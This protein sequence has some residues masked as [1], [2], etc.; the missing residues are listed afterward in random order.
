M[1]SGD[2]GFLGHDVAGIVASARLDGT[3][4]GIV[5]RVCRRRAA[6]RGVFHFGQI[7][8]GHSGDLVAAKRRVLAACGLGLVARLVAAARPGRLLRLHRLCIGALLGKKRLTVGDGDLVVIRM[9]FRK[10]EEAVAIPAVID[11][12]R[13]QRRLDAR[14]LR[15][16][17]VSG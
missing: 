6:L 11:K 10:R 16:I 15:K 3:G 5:S 12:G 1:V 7:D 9:D 14:H 8:D 4:D 2:I 13:L 17:D